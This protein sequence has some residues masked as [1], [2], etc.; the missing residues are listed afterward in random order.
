[1]II[2]GNFFLTS[3]KKTSYGYLLE[4]PCQVASDEYPQHVFMENWR[5]LHLSQNYH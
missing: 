5:K 2:W 4:A 1:M 3:P